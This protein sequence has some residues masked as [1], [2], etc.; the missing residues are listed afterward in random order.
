MKFIKLDLLTLLIGL[1]LLSS[2]KD[3]N[4]IGF[5]LDPTLA[6]KGTLNNTLTVKTVTEK[7]E[8][9]STLGLTGHALGYIN[10]D[11]TFGDTEAALSMAVSL[12]VAGI[13]FGKN[14]VIDSAVLVLP[15]QR[16]IDNVTNSVYNE[17]YGDT[18]TSIYS[19]KVQQLKQDITL[20][21]DFQSNREFAVETP[22]LGTFKGKISPNT[23]VKVNDIV[24][25]KPD[26]ARLI[27]PEIRIKLDNSFIQNNI[28]NL[29]SVTLAKN[30]RFSAI[31]RG[32]QVSVDKATATGKGG[33]I[34]VDFAGSNA[35]LQLYYK[36]DVTNSIA[37]DTVSVSFPISITTGP[38]ASNIKH[39]YTGTPV[40][41]Q[42]TTPS[43]AVP[44]NNV[45]LQG[46]TG[47]RTKLSFP[48]LAAFV[49]SVK[50][51]NSNSKI[52]INRAELVVNI[53]NGTDIAP[54]APARK[55]SLYRNDIAGQR[56][57]LTDYTP[58]T[59][60]IENQ[61]YVGDNSLVIGRYDSVN[62]RYIFILTSYLQEIIDGTTE[63][64]GTY[65]SIAG[66][67][68]TSL[69]PTVI[70]SSRSIISTVNPATGDKAIKLN[71]YYTKVN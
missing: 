12:Q 56:V 28:L 68:Q 26:T 30:S 9:T 47:L 32:L 59:N 60:S 27:V 16:P 21:N 17:F 46:L 44:Y 39:D 66:S 40:Q 22:V 50:G 54:F 13:S 3:P 25:G 33:I 24:V 36:K 6:V 4:T 63:D 58:S 1:F 41:T 49:A 69:S 51:T 5:E 64:Y 70:S 31:F 18:T 35:N 65:L 42:L 34:M 67:N 19:F 20:Q 37:K 48:D 11:P 62:K 10:D 53:S 15:Y 38:V 57:N 55:L 52:V 7:D 61:K 71:I 29:D 45:Y 8:A 2:C 43:P 23:P 14:P